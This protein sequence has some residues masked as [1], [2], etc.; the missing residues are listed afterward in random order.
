[1]LARSDRRLAATID[2]WDAD[3][4]LF[5]TP[6]GTVK[7]K[8]GEMHPHRREDYITKISAVTP[9]G[10]CPKFIEFL[11]TIFARD[12][13]L[14]DYI[15]KVFGYSL[16]GDTREHALFFF[17]GTGANGKSVLVSTMAGILGDYH[18]TAPIETFVATA[19]ASH[20]TDLAG[21]RGA[22]LVT[23]VE[24]EEGRRWAELKIK[25]LTGGDRISARFMRQDFFEFTPEFK[26]IIAGNHKPGLRSVDEAI[27]RRFHLVPFAVTIPPEDR[28]IDLA[29]K[30]RTE[31]R[32]ILQWAIEGC[33]KWQAEGNLAKPKAVADATAAYLEAEDAMAA[34][35]EDRC[36][37][38]ASFED[39]AAKL[40]ASWK[41][42]AEL[43]G[44]FVGS[45]KQF[46]EK[47]QSRG[48]ERKA[49]GHKNARGLIKNC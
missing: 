27:R 19:I 10:A 38:K 25:S 49:I 42:W 1:M 28:D 23:A 48:F 35:V 2:Q 36:E 43:N 47:L 12:Q 22:R 26:L 41:A 39:T 15:Q 8:T 45:Q 37:C 6:G 3:P 7:L 11:E 16:T 29:N 21:L 40:F 24:T 13:E 46:A 32:G 4:W 14:I 5:N 20:P 17:H 34:W 31:W 9:A 30:L 44:E 33:L 18:K